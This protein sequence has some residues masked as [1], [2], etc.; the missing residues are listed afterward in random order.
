VE[1]EP[2]AD[3]EVEAESEADVMA[4]GKASAKA[5]GMFCCACPDPRLDKKMFIDK[6]HS[7]YCADAPT[8]ENPRLS[9]FFK[10]R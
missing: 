10:W 4:V 2:E 5:A 3:A 9:V 6:C 7:V 8:D 1:A